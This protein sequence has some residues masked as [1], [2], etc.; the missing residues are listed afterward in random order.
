MKNLIK[1]ICIVILTLSVQ[2]CATYSIST[3]G[4]ETV[5]EQQTVNQIHINFNRDYRYQIGYRPYRFNP[6]YSWYRDVY[7]Y[8]Y[9]W[10]YM[11]YNGYQN[12]WNYNNYWGYNSY[13]PWHHH[14]PYTS[15]WMGNVYN[16]YSY[17]YTYGRR[18]SRLSRRYSTFYSNSNR[19]SLLLYSDGS[20]FNSRTLLPINTT[21]SPITKPTIRYIKPVRTTKPIRTVRPVKPQVTTRPIVTV[22]PTIY[23][24]PTRVIKSN[25]GS[26]SRPNSNS[27]SNIR[28][29]PI[30]R[31][32]QKTTTN[33]TRSRRNPR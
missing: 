26:S 30:K 7:S 3:I 28:V 12:P 25:S 18:G 11:W 10:N 27:R 33:K 23:I 15:G 17:G 13:N 21:A 2:S 14:H 22:K 5:Q 9:Q 29:T 20:T 31:S 8:N 4:H 24:K 1:L 32:V 16:N 19:S 6:H